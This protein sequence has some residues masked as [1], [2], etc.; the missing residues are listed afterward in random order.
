MTAPDICE[1]A[2]ASRAPSKPQSIYL[3]GRNWGIADRDL[4]PQKLG[5]NS[6]S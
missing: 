1:I 4:R 3:D 6:S 2:L 5:S